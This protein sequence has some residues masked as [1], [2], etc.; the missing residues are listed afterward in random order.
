[1]GVD[2]VVCAASKAV[3]GQVRGNKYKELQD[4]HKDAE[5]DEVVEGEEEEGEARRR[6]GVDEEEVKATDA[7]TVLVFVFLVFLVVAGW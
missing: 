2:V 5:A 1:V 3:E 4:E 7:V 6:G